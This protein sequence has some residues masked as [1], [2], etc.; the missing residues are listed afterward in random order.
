MPFL[1]SSFRSPEK[2]FF[3][4]IMECP[5]IE[6]IDIL[7]QYNFKIKIL[8]SKILKSMWVFSKI[9]YTRDFQKQYMHSIFQ[10]ILTMRCVPGTTL[11]LRSA[12]MCYITKA[13]SY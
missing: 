10:Q 1:S 13:N 6:F 11:A 9:V 2:P 8:F 5:C 7:R 3:S 12:A 4:Y